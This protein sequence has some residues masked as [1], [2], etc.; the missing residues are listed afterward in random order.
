MIAI[1]DFGVGN[2]ASIHNMLKKI[3]VPSVI[4]TDP[5]VA[6]KAEKLILPGVGNFDY[7]MQKFTSSGLVD[8]VEDVVLNQKKPILGICVGCQM[9]MEESEE[10]VNKGLGWIK[11]KVARFKPELAS[12][13]I[14]V[15]HMNWTDITARP[16]VK[17]YDKIEYPR[18]YFVHSYH[19][20][21]DEES[22]VSATSFYGYSFAASVEK[23]NIYGVQFHPEKSHKYGMQ[24]LR[25]FYML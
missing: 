19:L 23:Q 17:L 20:V 21:C 22:E 24:L 13:G 11:G 16:G 10:G 25:N 9:M 15:P 5:E 4:T 12:E 3:G 14:K 7:C 8:T 2:L 1:L 6:R 18:F